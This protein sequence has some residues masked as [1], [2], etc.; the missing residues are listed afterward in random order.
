[1]PQALANVATPEQND[2]A[3][4][5]LQQVLEYRFRHA[6][7]TGQVNPLLHLMLRYKQEVKP[8][9]TQN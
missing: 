8:C 1:M 6:L 2:T 9:Q 4:D 5:A 7:R 3:R